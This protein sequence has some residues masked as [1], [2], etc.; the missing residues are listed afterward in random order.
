M[1]TWLVL[2]ISS[3]QVEVGAQKAARPVSNHVCANV[4][5]EVTTSW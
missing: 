4:W 5:N 1:P 2:E 3:S